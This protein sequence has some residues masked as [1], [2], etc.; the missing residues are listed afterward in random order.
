VLLVLFTGIL[1]KYE[2]GLVEVAQA[3]SPTLSPAFSLAFSLAFSPAHSHKKTAPAFPGCCFVLYKT[4]N[5]S[6]PIIPFF[7]GFF[8]VFCCSLPLDGLI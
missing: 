2:Y 6:A 8:A 1:S 7:C 5:P 4:F 3:F